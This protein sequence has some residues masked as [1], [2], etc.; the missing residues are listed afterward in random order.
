[1]WM[2]A[3]PSVD[4]VDTTMQPFSVGAGELPAYA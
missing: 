1:V 4:A 3:L 2:S